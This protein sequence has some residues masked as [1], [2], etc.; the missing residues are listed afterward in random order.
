MKLLRRHVLNTVPLLA[1][2]A[3]FIFET[4]HA[5]SP[6]DLEDARAERTKL[7]R[8]ADQIELFTQQAETQRTEIAALQTQVTD[9]KSQLAAQTQEL[10][11]IRAA[12]EK[13]EVAR[14]KER[15]TL[16][17]E[18]SKLVAGH[19]SPPA[20]I[21]AASPPITTPAAP[22][23]GSAKE[24]GYWHT[25]ESGQT[26]SAIAAAYQEQGVHVTVEELRRKNKLSK[27]AKL[28]VGQKLFIPKE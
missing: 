14:A 16:L 20:S 18:V 23:A 10:A 26:L 17:A 13:S 3:V 24:K 12:L 1:L 11:A 2:C 25:V 21:A 6:G 28:K 4:T 7:L 27:D 9:L 19:S 15:E 8:A 22:S 5:Q